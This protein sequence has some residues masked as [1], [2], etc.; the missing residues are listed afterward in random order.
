MRRRQ[1]IAVLGSAVAAR[2]IVAAGQQPARIAR[3]GFLG[4]ASAAGWATKVD[5]MRDGLRDLG[6]VEGKKLPLSSAGPMVS[7]IA[8]LCW[9]QS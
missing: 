8:S 4:T 7:T 9:Q 6:Y 1:F 2:P 3:I 5:A